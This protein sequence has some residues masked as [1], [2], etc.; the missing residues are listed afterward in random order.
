ML[1]VQRLSARRKLIAHRFSERR[2]LFANRSFGWSVYLPRVVADPARL[3]MRIRQR[4]SVYLN[5]LPYKEKV[6]GSSPPLP[7]VPIA[8]GA[9]RIDPGA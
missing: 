7:T 4:R 1:G 3:N 8:T 9:I 5:L 2:C 6:G